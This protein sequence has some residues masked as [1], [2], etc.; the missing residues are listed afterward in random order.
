M[1]VVVVDADAVMVAVKD[2]VEAAEEVMTVKAVA[3]AEQAEEEVAAAEVQRVGIVLRG[4]LMLLLLDV[5]VVEEEDALQPLVRT[6][7]NRL[8]RRSTI[9]FVVQH[10][11]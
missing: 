5:V 4:L 11:T 2:V 9:S 10:L 8:L 6:A 1:V 3:E 7:V